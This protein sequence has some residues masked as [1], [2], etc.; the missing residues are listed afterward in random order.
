M[1]HESFMFN[2][3]FCKSNVLSKDKGEIILLLHPINEHLKLL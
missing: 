3:F 2:H 1:F